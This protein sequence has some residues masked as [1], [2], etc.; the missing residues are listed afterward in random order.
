MSDYTHG[1]CQVCKEKTWLKDGKCKKC[2]DGGEVPEF[3]SN[4]FSGK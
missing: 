1:S 2:Q 4:L 3:L